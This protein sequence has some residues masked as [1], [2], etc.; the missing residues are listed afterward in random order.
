MALRND[1]AVKLTPQQLNK[2]ILGKSDITEQ[3]AREHCAELMKVYDENRRRHP[4]IW[5]WSSS[6]LNLCPICVCYADTDQWAVRKTHN[7]NRCTWLCAQVPRTRKI[8]GQA[9]AKVMETVNRVTKARPPNFNF[10]IKTSPPANHTNALHAKQAAS[11][12]LLQMEAEEPDAM[13][14]VMTLAAAN[15]WDK[16]D[17]NILRQAVH[18]LLDHDLITIDQYNE[19]N[20]I[21]RGHSPATV[22]AAAGSPSAAFGFEQGGRF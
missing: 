12:M 16:Y 2:V 18:E 7:A 21:L 6:M 13:N 11:Q 4:G 22:A 3:E 10:N 15:E 17:G 19:A 9:A 5:E 20:A 1:V 8:M 14:L